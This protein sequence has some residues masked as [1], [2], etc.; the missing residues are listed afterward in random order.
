MSDLSLYVENETMNH[1]PYLHKSER[2][3]KL[4]PPRERMDSFFFSSG[5]Q[6]SVHSRAR[7]EGECRLFVRLLARLTAPA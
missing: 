4:R 7:V 5:R 1:W 2:I 3:A 6:G